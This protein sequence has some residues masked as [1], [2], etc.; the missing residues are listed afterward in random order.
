M[1]DIKLKRPIIIISGWSGSGKTTLL[2]KVIPL[3]VAKGLR[4]NVMKSSH[5]NVEVEPLHKDSARLRQAGAAEVLLTSPYRFAIFHELHEGKKPSLTELLNRMQ[6]A[7]LTLIEGFHNGLFPKLE[8]HRPAL[9]K[10][11]IFPNDHSIEAVASD[12]PNPKNFRKSV[13]WLNLNDA[14]QVVDW[15]LERMKN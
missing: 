6:E 3:L 13:V 12:V 9:G 8:I 10:P 1:S 11:L 14:M 4:V 5:H 7:D 2:E 15:L